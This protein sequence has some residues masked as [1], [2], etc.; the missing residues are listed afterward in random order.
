MKYRVCII[1]IIAVLIAG[2]AMGADLTVEK[3]SGDLSVPVD[4]FAADGLTGDPENSYAWS[5]AEFGGYIYAGTNRNYLRQILETAGA[6]G[7]TDLMD[8]MFPM[9]IDAKAKIYRK[10]SDGSETGNCSMNPHGGY[11]TG[12]KSD[13]RNPGQRI[14]RMEVWN[15]SLYI[16]TYSFFSSP[17]EVV[18]TFGPSGNRSRP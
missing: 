5:M 10:P 7:L 11:N 4:P 16:V 1:A 3:W 9:K 2:A 18:E 13:V 15:N 14:R 12:R 6:S 8:A 17:L